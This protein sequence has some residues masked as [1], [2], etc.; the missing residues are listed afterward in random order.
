MFDSDMCQK[1]FEILPTPMFIVDYE[2]RIKHCNVAALSLLNASIDDVIDRRGG[3]AL[4]CINSNN[5][6]GGC[7]C[8]DSCKSCTILNSVTSTFDPGINVIQEPAKLIIYING[9]IT[10]VEALITTLV[11]DTETS[12]L[13]IENI[14]ELTALKSLIPMCSSCK[15]IR[16]DANYWKSVEDYI[17]EITDADVTHGM[18]PDCIKKHHPELADEIL[19]EEKDYKY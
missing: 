4:H 11:L 1:I 2:I 8:T 17:V 7:G 15:N 3:T 6:V 5:S 10:Q 16:N 14:T 18:C 9:K 12:L 19:K 13:M